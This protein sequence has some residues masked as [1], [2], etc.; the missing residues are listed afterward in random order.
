MDAIGPVSRW[1]SYSV[2]AQPERVVYVI[3]MISFIGLVVTGLPLKYG[4]MPWARRVASWVGGFSDDER[5]SSLVCRVADLGLPVSP[6]SDGAAP[7]V[8]TAT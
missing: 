6:R 5:V 4:T 7:V 1:T 8:Q 2:F 3:L